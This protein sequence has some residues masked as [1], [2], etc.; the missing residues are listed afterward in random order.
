MPRKRTLIPSPLAWTATPLP[1]AHPMLP[2]VAERGGT[3]LRTPLP[4]AIVDTREQNPLSFRRFRGWFQKIE[5]RALK[6]G[7]YSVKGMEDA[8]A[9]ERKDLAD[10]IQS[11]TTNRAVFVARLRRM[12]ELPHSLLVVT[13]SLTEIKSEYPY[14]AANPNRITQSLIAVLTGLRLPFICT[15]THELGEEIV[16][17]Y[18]YQTFLYEWL[19]RNGHGRHLADGDL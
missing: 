3:Q 7:D 9:V 1:V 6:L 2:V 16:A 14:R 4:V 11:F 12:S 18:L 13:S 10:L 17:S 15:D 19:D 5:Y 8:L